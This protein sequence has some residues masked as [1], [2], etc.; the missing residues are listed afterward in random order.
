MSTVQVMLGERSY[1]IRIRPGSLGRSGRGAGGASR[2]DARGGDHLE[3]RR[4]RCTTGRWRPAWRARTSSSIACSC[5]TASAPRRCASPRASTTGWSTSTSRARR[6]VIG[7][8]GGANCDLAGFVASTFLR[9]LPLVQV[10]TTLLAQV[11][12]SVGG[13]TA[14]NHPLRQEPDRHLLPAAPGVGRPGRARHLVA[15]RAARG[16]GRGDQGRRDLGRGL[17]QVARGELGGAARARARRCSRVRRRARAGSRPRSSGSTSARPGLRA[18]LN[19]GHTLGHAVEVVNGYRHVRHGEAVALGMAFAARLSERRGVAPGGTPRGWRGCSRGLA[20]ATEIADLPGQRAAYLRA[21]AVD[22]KGTDGAL[23]FVVAAR[24]RARGAVEV[25]A[26]GNPGGGAVSGK[27][28]REM[29]L[30][31]ARVHWALGERAE[32]LGALERAADAMPRSRRAARAGRRLLE[33]LEAGDAGDL[34]ARLAGL[35]A[36][37]SRR[38][39]R[40]SRPTCRRRSRRRR[41]RACS[42]SRVTARRRSRSRKTCCAATR[43]RARARL[44]ASMPG[45]R[46]RRP[47]RTRHR[48]RARALAR[49][50]RARRNARE[51]R[52]DLPRDPADARGQ[53]PGCARRRRDGRRRAS[54]STSTR[55]AAR[56]SISPGSRVE[57]QARARRRRS[58]VRARSALGDGAAAR[59]CCSAPATTSSCFRRIDDEYLPGRRARRDGVVG[60]ARYLARPPLQESAVRPCKLRLRAAHCAILVL[61]GPNLNLLGEREPEVYG[62]HHARRDRRAPGASGRA[63]AAPRS[64]RFQSNHEGAL[65]DRHPGRAAHVTGDRSSIR[66]G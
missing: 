30:E 57:F 6:V 17:L 54:R 3:A 44:R 60:K 16:S 38:S 10:P 47:H 28:P 18:L 15:A 36:R 66:A 62:T 2:S 42:S 22:K 46:G 65:I 20:C 26:R 33:E 64:R 50:P 7:L 31:L 41:W 52:H 59:S 9:G 12:A 48:R 11:D 14:V 13:K 58:K 5:P 63:S 4:G 37:R 19:F 51:R 8:G 24:D 49:R 55:R 45:R 39:T 32:A 56:T 40:A 53:T 29:R 27:D 34:A 43:R 35:R 1:P 21:L 61:H 23:S 25:D